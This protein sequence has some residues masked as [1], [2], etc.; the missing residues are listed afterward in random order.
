MRTAPTSLFIVIGLALC[1][2]AGTDAS[3]QEV[4][5]PRA[6]ETANVGIVYDR[7]IGFPVTLHTNG[8]T[9]GFTSGKLK[10][11]YKT[12]YWGFSVGHLKHPREFKQSSN[13]NSS[14]FRQNSSSFIFGKQRTVIPV[15]INKGWKRYYSGKDRRRGVAVGTVFEVGASIAV[16]KSYS[17]QIATQ[18]EIGGSPQFFNYSDDPE[19]FTTQNLIEGAGG[20]QRG[21][22]D[23]NIYPGIHAKAAIHL[24]WGAFD[25]YMKAVEAG[26]MVD[27]YAS[28]VDILVPETNNTPLFINFYLG[29]RLG[30]RS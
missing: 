27:F 12:T 9:V 5:Y 1:L 11:Y 18:G 22:D 13:P 19:R 6:Y 3:G 30:K 24:D 15:R 14:G 28:E 20:L 29:L 25:E 8:F 17:L 4:I 10:S 16:A 26:I 21:W 7:E 23:T 2:A